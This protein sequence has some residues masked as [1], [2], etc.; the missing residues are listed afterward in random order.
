M[1][2]CPDIKI[3]YARANNILGGIPKAT[4]SSKVMGGLTQ[5]MLS[6]DISLEGVSNR[7][8]YLV[9]PDSVVQ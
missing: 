9:F 3:K 4:P 7:V 8:N 5:F 1:D 6:Q 2:N